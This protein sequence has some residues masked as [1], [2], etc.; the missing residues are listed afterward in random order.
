MRLRDE[1]QHEG[2]DAKI[3]LGRPGELTVRVDGKSVWSH[4]KDAAFPQ[5]GEI[6]K[7]LRR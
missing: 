1:L 2:I 7:L 6:A 4:D 3:K 5:P